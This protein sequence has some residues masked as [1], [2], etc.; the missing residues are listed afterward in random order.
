M[1][2][3][4]FQNKLTEVKQSPIHGL[5]LFAKKLIRKGQ[6]IH[7]YE[8][9]LIDELAFR[10]LYGNDTRYC[11]RFIKRV[12]PLYKGYIVGKEEPYLSTNAS[13]YCN[14]SIA[15]NAYFLRR[16]LIASRDIQAGEEVFLHYP[17]SYPR[18]YDPN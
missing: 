4:K 2:P 11:Y 8:G 9:I 12:R 16:K 6:C 15:P 3:A 13:H 7:K 14:E 18:N 1:D 5:G 10:E 17:D